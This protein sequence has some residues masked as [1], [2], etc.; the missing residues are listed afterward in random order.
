MGLSRFPPV[1]SIVLATGGLLLLGW[2]GWST[3]EP[4]GHTVTVPYRYQLVA[5]GGIDQFPE[6]GLQQADLS[7]NKY[8]VRS[9]EIGEPLATLHVGTRQGTDHTGPVLLDWHNQLAEPLITLSPP[10]T[11]VSALVKAVEAHLPQGALVLGWW[12]TTRRL[13]L[14]TDVDTPFHKNLSQPVLLPTV[15]NG[16]REA[17]EEFERNFWGVPRDGTTTA[18]AVFERLQAAL[19]TDKVAGA[20]ALRELAGDRDAYL[21]LHVADAYKL[22]VLNQERFGIGYRD[23]PNSGNL[24]SVIG[25]IKK[26]LDDNGYESYTVE[27]LSGTSVRVYFLT[28]T[29]SQQTLIAQALP[30]TTSQPL[31]LETLKVVYQHKGYWVY[32][33]SAERGD[34]DS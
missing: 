26:W 5:K 29:Q 4:F 34:K 1:A 21:V 2:I 11:E 10:I 25:H 14:L 30:F 3:L 9:D 18:H 12:D 19:L 32:R 22:G 16:H 15:W 27:K 17:I 24:H 13:A 8:E 20:A 28:E 6:L 7:I 33:I 23:F 31:E